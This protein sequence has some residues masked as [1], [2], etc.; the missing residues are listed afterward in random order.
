MATF[1]EQSPLAARERREFT[2]FVRVRRFG[3]HQIIYTLNGDDVRVTRV[4]HGRSDWINDP[5]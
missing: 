4:A 1:I 5:G 3:A 2:P